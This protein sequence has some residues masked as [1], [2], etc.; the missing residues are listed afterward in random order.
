MAI[1]ITSQ[2]DGSTLAV[3]VTVASEVAISDKKL[4]LYLV[5]DGII[6]DQ[7]NYY[8]EDEGSPF[9]GLGNPIPNYEHKD[10]LRASLTDIFGDA[11]SATPA[12]TDV[13]ANYS[14]ELNSAFNPEKL[15]LVAMVVGPDNTAVN[16]QEATV[17]STVGY[18]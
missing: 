17:D 9:F 7:V 10:V 8:N 6:A 16:G 1:G 13:T 18:E 15:R 3:Q 11:I 12:L 14:I 4:V 5:E 2:L